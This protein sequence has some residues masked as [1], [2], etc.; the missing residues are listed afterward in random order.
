LTISRA[1]R[2]SHATEGHRHRS[3]GLRN[4][5]GWQGR[6]FLAAE[7]RYRGAR[8]GR[9]VGCQAAADRV[10]RQLR[11][12]AKAPRRTL[13]Y[14]FESAATNDIS[15]LRYRQG[16]ISMGRPD[17]SLQIQATR[18][19]ESSSLCSAP[20]SPFL[21]IAFLSLSNSRRNEPGIT[22]PFLPSLPSALKAR[23]TVFG[24]P[25]PSLSLS[26]PEFRHSEIKEAK[27]RFLYFPHSKR[28][29]TAFSL[30]RARCL[31]SPRC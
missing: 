29:A 24:S 9:R 21:T 25:P 30:P 11:Q 8:D 10:D 4:R 15:I 16:S 23:P 31:P 6:G 13:F 19:G 27:V 26:A 28:E 12:S 17:I 22:P 7:S 3:G 20:L 5:C 2:T 18:G 1:A 14:G